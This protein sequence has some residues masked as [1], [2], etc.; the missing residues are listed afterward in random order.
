MGYPVCLDIKRS[1]STVKHSQL[2]LPPALCTVH[3]QNDISRNFIPPS[4][5]P[6]QWLSPRLCSEYNAGD[7]DLLSAMATFLTAE[8]LFDRF[9]LRTPHTHGLFH[10]GTRSPHFIPLYTHHARTPY[11]FTS[12]PPLVSMLP[13]LHLQKSPAYRSENTRLGRVSCSPT[14]TSDWELWGVFPLCVVGL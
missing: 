9:S 7:G 13:H 10:P 6:E 11:L 12:L 4:N 8:T 1:S 14:T 2:G 3:R 5:Y